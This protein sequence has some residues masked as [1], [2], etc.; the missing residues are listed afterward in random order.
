LSHCES[1]ISRR[2]EFLREERGTVVFLPFNLIQEQT[3]GK[4]DFKNSDRYFLDPTKPSLVKLVETLR[5][6]PNVSGL[7]SVGASGIFQ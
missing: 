5:Y 2:H 7:I 4:F 1:I 3:D 6:K